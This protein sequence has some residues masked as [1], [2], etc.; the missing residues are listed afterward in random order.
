MNWWIPT[1]LRR[2]TVGGKETGP[3]RDAIPGLPGDLWARLADGDP[4]AFAAIYRQ[5]APAIYRFVLASS[6]SR[7]T[8]EEVT[9]ETF[10]F[11][12]REWRRYDHAR[13]PLEAWLLGIARQMLRRVRR[14]SGSGERENSLVEDPV[15][16]TRDALDGMLVEE[17]QQRLHVAV[18][19]LPEVYREALVLHALEGRPY[20]E[21]AVLLDCAVGTVRSRIARAKELLTRE[22][23]S[24]ERAHAPPDPIALEPTG[25]IERKG[26]NDAKRNVAAGI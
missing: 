4:E 18:S 6:A 9:Q 23:N 5:H 13:G 2:A 22:L 19:Q 16:P 12:L 7:E 10:L 26:G 15:C 21:I 3:G 25:E 8:A 20:A 24:R 11:L 17:Q 14:G 1:K